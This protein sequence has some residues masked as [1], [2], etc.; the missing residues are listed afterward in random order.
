VRQTERGMGQEHIV[1]PGARRAL[2]TNA[3]GVECESG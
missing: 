1:K 2:R 3:Y